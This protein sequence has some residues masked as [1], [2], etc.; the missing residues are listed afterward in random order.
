MGSM[1]VCFHN[2]ARNTKHVSAGAL[3]HRQR[4]IHWIF[5]QI[6]LSSDY[7]HKPIVTYCRRGSRILKWGVNFCD[8]VIDPNVICDE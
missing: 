1:S 4:T 3:I 2:K 7:R 6:I 8:N 5:T